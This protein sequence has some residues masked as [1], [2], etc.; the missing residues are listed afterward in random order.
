MVDSVN[1]EGAQFAMHTGD[2]KGGSDPCDDKFYKRFE[3][4]SNAMNIPSLLT[5]GDNGW[6]DCHRTAAGGF[7]PLDRLEV[8]RERFYAPSI[9]GQNVP[10]VMGGTQGAGQII[11]TT[12]ANKGYPEHQRFVFN[13]V[14][15]V[16]RMRQSAQFHTPFLCQFLDHFFRLTYHS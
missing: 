4:M 8:M 16:V 5:L 9:S 3:D 7:D 15:Y 1:S 12:Q 13:G 10:N 6:T 2:V 11:M 14:M